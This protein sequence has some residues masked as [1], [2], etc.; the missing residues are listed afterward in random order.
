MSA[1]IWL[2]IASSFSVLTA[3][4]THQENPNYQY[5][6][7][8]K[9][10][11][12]TTTY[13][14]SATH[15]AS[16]NYQT[17]SY[18]SSAPTSY[19]TIDQSCLRK[20]KNHE[21][22]GA[23][24]GGT[25]GA[26]AGKE[27]IGGT[28]GTAFGAGVGGTLGYGLGNATVD[29]TQQTYA[30]QGTLP[31]SY[32]VTQAPTA[33]SQTYT[34]SSHLPANYQYATTGES[35]VYQS[36]RIVHQTPPPQVVHQSPQQEFHQSSQVVHQSAQ[37]LHQAPTDTQFSN[38]SETGTPGYQVL[39]SQ[40]ISDQAP[41]SVAEVSRASTRSVNG[42]SL[43]DY[44][45]SDN[46]ISVNAYSAPEYSETRFL[47]D[48]NASHRVKEGDTVYSLARRN[49]VTVGD[50]QSINGLNADF[51]IKIGDDLRLP[52]SRC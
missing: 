50:I 15:S 45:Y 36:P 7:K 26:F 30:S 13:A 23:G 12:P 34:S 44:D 21:L 35:V 41:I 29:C 48:D 22:I 16:S 49:C 18:A 31:S 47:N 19:S 4:A 39:Q 24:L 17:A 11:V 51:A 42:A 8:Y 14:S 46:I 3:C 52:A 20:E 6:T 33:S 28:A 40:V 37:V 43:V 9:G 5:S 1:K 2:C 10:G 25:L 38:I 27:I 32:T